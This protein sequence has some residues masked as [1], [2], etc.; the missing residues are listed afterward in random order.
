MR[1]LALFP[2]VLL[3]AGCSPSSSPAP[4]KA[5]Q[6]DSTSHTT[7]GDAKPLDWHHLE[8]P[9]LTDHVE[10]TSRDQFVRAGE[11]YF[12]HN[13]PPK[14]IIFQ[15]VPV[16]TEHHEPDP[17]YSMYVARLTWKG[18]RLAGIDRPIKISP[19]GSANTCGWFDPVTGYKVIFGSTLIPPSQTQRPGFQ[20]GSRKY[21]WSFPSEM[22]IVSR[23][24][25]EIY[26]ALNP[27]APHPRWG[28]D[29]ELAQPVFKRPNYDAEC[30]FSR[31]GRF[32]LYAHVRDEPTRGKDDADIWLYDTQTAQQH[33]LVHA[34]GYDGGP[35][36]SPDNKRI[37][38]RSDRAGNDLLQLY[39]A[40]LQFD[41]AGVPVGVE[42]EHQITNNEHVN[43][44]PFW[45]P[46]GKFLIY[47][48]SEEGH[49]N[50]E[51]FAVE[52]PDASD[53]STQPD[54][55]R[56]RRITWADGADV[57][58]VFSHDGK[59]MMWTAQRGPKHDDE[60]K[61]SSQVWAAHFNMP[62][63][64]RGLNAFDKFFMPRFDP[65]ATEKDAIAIA[66]KVIGPRADNATFRVEHNKTDWTVTAIMD[67]SSSAA[68]CTV[69]IDGMGQITDVNPP[70]SSLGGPSR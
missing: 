59:Y 34:D 67:P 58:P 69:S 54:Q 19:E 57:L 25:P 63:D 10:L 17:F 4:K 47:G 26:Y 33:E 5:E 55:L 65:P 64:G 22:E 35:F 8:A 9:L 21:I 24:V 6:A 32:I 41:S 36:F 62:H 29:S 7:Q 2:L 31:D 3:A 37:C 11:A 56:K 30:S 68:Q 70:L 50:Y 51:V 20:V 38:Y 28:P 61:P 46:S 48:T 44:A 49:T 27:N 66:R 40:D 13:S 53:T 12:D 1:R 52:V 16:P 39:V 45:H 43:W 60:E 42:H 23:T 15:A 18:E 14:W